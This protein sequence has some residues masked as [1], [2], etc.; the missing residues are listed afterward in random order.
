MEDGEIYSKIIE[1]EKDDDY[2]LN[3]WDDYLV[4]V[5]QYDVDWR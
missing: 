3:Y 4:S 1:L 2:G 5:G